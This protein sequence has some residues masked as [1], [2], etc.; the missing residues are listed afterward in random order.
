MAVLDVYAAMLTAAGCGGGKN[1]MRRLTGLRRARG[2]RNNTK[3]GCEMEGDA[4]DECVEKPSNC[5]V[6]LEIGTPTVLING[7]FSVRGD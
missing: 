2:Y 3:R 5:A 6:A 7:V 4:V 1:A